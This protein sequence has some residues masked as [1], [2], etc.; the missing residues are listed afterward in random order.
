VDGVGFFSNAL[1]GNKGFIHNNDV[2]YGIY[3]M[4]CLA[5]DALS[6]YF[7]EKKQKT[8]FFI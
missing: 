4:G 1:V 5:Y 6:Q 8:V 7:Q 2:F 3:T